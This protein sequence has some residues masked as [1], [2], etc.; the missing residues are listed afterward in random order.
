MHSIKDVLQEKGPLQ[1]CIG[2]SY[3]SVCSVTAHADDTLL[4]QAASMYV[5]HVWSRTF[6]APS[7]HSSTSIVSATS[8]HLPKRQ[9]QS[10]AVDD[11]AAS[12]SPHASSLPGV[13]GGLGSRLAAD[14]RLRP[15][16]SLASADM[17]EGLAARP[18]ADL[19]LPSLRPLCSLASADKAASTAGSSS[20]G[21]GSSSGGGSSNGDGSSS[22]GRRDGGGS[23]D[24]NKV[25]AS[26]D[27]GGGGSDGGGGSSGSGEEVLHSSDNA[28]T[29]DRATS[30][31]DREA[32]SNSAAQILPNGVAQA[33]KPYRNSISSLPLPSTPTAEAAQS[34]P[35]LSE[36]Q[37]C[38]A[39][40]PFWQDPGHP[41]PTSCPDLTER[42][43][44]EVQE[45]LQA[46]MPRLPHLQLSMER[47]LSSIMEI[48]H[49]S[50]VSPDRVVMRQGVVGRGGC[51]KINL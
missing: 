13:A 37:A 30:P 2:K 32:S 27:G 25:G 6:T 34:D 35:P 46:C 45:Y 3:M 41:I 12:T 39:Q 14:L 23:N 17:A 29:T 36:A 40:L 51:G 18:A 4:L 16:C 15:L 7:Q 1:V 47:R 8:W 20:S 50:G 42:R 11:C 31:A 9:H 48:A 5:S 38:F 26:S 22:G 21:D 24:G 19:H 49:Y 43:V 28:G 33:L 10:P 44:Q